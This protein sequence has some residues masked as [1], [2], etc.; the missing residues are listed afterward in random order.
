MMKKLVALLLTL[1]VLFSLAACGTENSTE[2][3]N[4]GMTFA[5][6]YA[7]L[8]FNALSKLISPDV[9]VEPFQ[10]I[11][12]FD[13]SYSQMGSSVSFLP[14]S[15]RLQ[16]GKFVIKMRVN[17]TVSGE[18]YSHVNTYYLSYKR[19]GTDYFATGLE[20]EGLTSEATDPLEGL[21]SYIAAVSSGDFVRV[22][23]MS[24]F[25]GFLTEAGRQ[26]QISRI[27]QS[28]IMDRKRVTVK[29]KQLNEDYIAVRLES[30]GNEFDTAFRFRLEN[31]CYLYSNQSFSVDLST[32][33][34]TCKAFFA[35]LQNVDVN[36]LLMT[37][38]AEISDAERAEM[39]QLFAQISMLQS[40]GL[41]ITASLDDLSEL[42]SSE[43]VYTGILR[44]SVSAS[45]NGQSQS[46]SL[47]AKVRLVCR[48][49]DWLISEMQEYLGYT[50]P[51]IVCETLCEALETADR[52]LLRSTVDSSLIPQDEMRA[53][54]SLRQDCYAYMLTAEEF[55]VE[56][57]RLDETSSDK[58]SFS[59]VL[60]IFVTK[61]DYQVESWEL[62]FNVKMVCR[63]GTWLFS[64][65]KES[66]Q[67]ERTDLTTSDKALQA[68]FDA[69][70][71]HDF[72][73]I[74]SVF[75]YDGLTTQQ[76]RL[77]QDFFQDIVARDEA[78]QAVYRIEEIRCLY[79]AVD[80]VE[81]Q[82][83]YSFQ[84]IGDYRSG[85]VLLDF[86]KTGRGWRL[87]PENYIYDGQ[88][89]RPDYSALSPKYGAIHYLDVL[90][91]GDYETILSCF[92]LEGMSA[93][94]RA[95]FCQTIRDYSR[96]TWYTYI[97]KYI[98]YT[99]YSYDMADIKVG[100]LWNGMYQEINF[101]MVRELGAWK[102]LAR[103]QTH[104]YTPDS[105]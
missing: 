19:D 1:S 38:D 68:Y 13:R 25:S 7:K 51:Q 77:I 72:D 70:N 22:V 27:Y 99:S 17:M 67:C 97:F 39:E 11:M 75:C 85:P 94:E 12:K 21:D 81:Y 24:D 4:F 10:E 29:S 36:Q 45:A 83:Y 41:R 9:K 66:E 62:V 98:E 89:T 31:G 82:V 32:P 61:V 71:A 35:A 104:M 42:E 52:E 56:L 46:Q 5:E 92:S 78:G 80:Y 54:N 58:T 74:M 6:S 93:A 73:L 28:V 53:L 65:V 103:S 40:Y 101:Q 105:Q 18:T 2:S 33:E 43:S 30:G 86:I 87:L 79:D 16:S 23:G 64:S 102:I 3:K 63:D 76:A 88:G 14:L 48:N 59:G 49:G 26:S 100:F 37:M 20:L 69:L 91:C 8:D 50:T 60:R 55:S 96:N 34:E 47:T 44:G 90:P 57:L 84:M 95:S 15:S